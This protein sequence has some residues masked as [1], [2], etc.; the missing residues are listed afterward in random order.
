[1]VEAF[2][3]K[4]KIYSLFQTAIYEEDQCDRSS[5]GRGAIPTG[6]G[7]LSEAESHCKKNG[8]FMAGWRRSGAAQAGEK[9]GTCVCGGLKKTKTKM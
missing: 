3:K 7:K 2:E 6:Q 5:Y 4:L 8:E 9:K 1:M